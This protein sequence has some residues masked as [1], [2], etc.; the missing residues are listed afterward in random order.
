LVSMFVPM[1]LALLWPSNE[2][3]PA[4]G[5]A[6]MT[7]GLVI[8]LLCFIAENKF[9]STWAL[10]AWTLPSELFGLLAS[11]LTGLYLRSRTTSESETTDNPVAT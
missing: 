5:A 8:W 11:A 1:C 6:T 7:V 10:G 3:R 9:G 4:L 2:I